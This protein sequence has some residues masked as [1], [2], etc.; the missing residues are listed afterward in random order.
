MYRFKDTEAK[1]TSIGTHTHKRTHRGENIEQIMV[2]CRP[3]PA[4]SSASGASPVCSLVGTGWVG[5]GGTLMNYPL[6]VRGTAFWQHV[7]LWRF[8]MVDFIALALER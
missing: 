8:W 1:R 7:G 3:L 5:N 4:I 2:L 6:P